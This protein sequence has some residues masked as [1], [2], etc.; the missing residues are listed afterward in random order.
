MF[1]ETKIPT[2]QKGLNFSPFNGKIIIW[3]LQGRKAVKCMWYARMERIIPIIDKIIKRLYKLLRLDIFC[4][5]G[6]FYIKLL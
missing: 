1:F 5:K 6:V 2:H 3:N 4:I